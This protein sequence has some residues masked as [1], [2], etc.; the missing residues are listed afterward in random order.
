MRET[1]YKKCMPKIKDVEKQL[2]SIISNIKKI[3]GIKSV[4]AW[5]SY[6]NNYEDS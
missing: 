4:Y 5:G 2:P 3:N 1:W 6:R